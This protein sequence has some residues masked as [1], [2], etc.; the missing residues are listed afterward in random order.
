MLSTDSAN[1]LYEDGGPQVE[2]HCLPGR[3]LARSKIGY[4]SLELAKLHRLERSQ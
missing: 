3:L 1:H 2:I 4:T